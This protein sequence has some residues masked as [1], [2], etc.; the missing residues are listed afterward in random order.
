MTKFA[1][2]RWSYLLVFLS[3]LVLAGSFYFD[4]SVVEWMRRHE[5]PGGISFMRAV[6]WWGDWPGHALSGLAGALIAYALGNRRWVTVFAAM[7]IAL[8]LASAVNRVI[9]IAAG[10]SRPSV[11][12]DAGWQALRWDSKHHAFPSGHTAS[13]TAFFATLCFA[14][15]RVGLLLLPIPLLIACSRLYLHAH[16]LSDVVF[17]AMLGTL[18]AFLVWRVLTRRMQLS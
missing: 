4:L 15:R 16:Y 2:L 8:T 14:R 12:V 18:C 3:A 13:S 11:T 6:S 9:K 5:T 10:R 7:L 17:A 1:R